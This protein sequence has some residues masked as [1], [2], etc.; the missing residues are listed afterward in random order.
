MICIGGAKKSNL[1]SPSARPLLPSLSLNHVPPTSPGPSP[2][3]VALAAAT[4]LSTGQIARARRF[5][6]VPCS[7]PCIATAL[8]QCNLSLNHSLCRILVCDLQLA[9]LNLMYN[10]NLLQ[11][12]AT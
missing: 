1:R 8:I 6:T 5:I 7:S 10:Y 3:P 12:H 2:T 4:A 9:A 11:I